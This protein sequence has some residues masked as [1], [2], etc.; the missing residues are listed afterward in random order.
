MLHVLDLKANYWS[1]WTESEHLA[2]YNER[3]P[4]GFER[5]R[6]GI[7]YRLRPSWVWQRKRNGASELIA[8]ISNRGGAGVPGVLW[9]TA[10]SPDGRLKLHGSFDP[11]HPHGGALRMGSFL[12][13]QGYVGRIDL[14]AEIEIRPNVIRSVAWACEQPL[15]AD[16][17]ISVDIKPVNDANWRKSI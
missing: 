12:L 8:A 4:R 13:P 3:Y 6:A 11:G 15:N 14:L 16:G 5:L 1:L 9:L 17:S 7:G 2:S 10:K